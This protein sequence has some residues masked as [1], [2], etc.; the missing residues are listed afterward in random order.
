VI[1]I[2]IVPFFET[3]VLTT[4]KGLMFRLCLPVCICVLLF[5]PLCISNTLLSFYFFH[6]SHFSVQ[7]S[8]YINI[9][10]VYI[11]RENVYIHILI[12]RNTETYSVTL[13]IGMPVVSHFIMV[14]IFMLNI[15]CDMLIYNAMLCVIVLLNCRKRGMARKE[16]LNR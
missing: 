16:I 13:N 7:G 10:F 14:G 5:F 8:S 6:F 15:F 1:V 3:D 12:Y 4:L 11:S 9:I 2:S